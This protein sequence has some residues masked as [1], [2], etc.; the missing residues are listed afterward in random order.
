MVRSQRGAEGAMIVVNLATVR[1]CEEGARARAKV[2]SLEAEKE[3]K[4][5][6]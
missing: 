3:P 6:R 5:K 4:R 2:V 1:W